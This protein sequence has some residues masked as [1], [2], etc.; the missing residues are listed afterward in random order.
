MT[1][2][3]ASAMACINSSTVETDASQQIPPTHVLPPAQ[4]RPPPQRHSPATH[5]PPGQVVLSSLSTGVLHVPPWQAACLHGFAGFGHCRAWRLAPSDAV[6]SWATGG[7]TSVA[8][9]GASGG[10]RAT[11]A[12]GAP[13]APTMPRRRSTTYSAG[14][15]S[16][17]TGG[18]GCSVRSGG[19][20]RQ[21]RTW[22]APR[23]R[24]GESQSGALRSEARTNAS[25]WL[26]VRRR[27]GNA[28]AHLATGVQRFT[29][30][31]LHLQSAAIG[32]SI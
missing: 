13:S 17:R 5:V 19:N 12:A 22:V 3:S 6:R 18:R 32:V 29:D 16:D 2:A 23:S 31:R 10:P 1:A 20:G 9:C 11:G 8:S 28:L 24:G 25:P 30:L 4:A 21:E 7:S 14:P 26:T 15:P 27:L